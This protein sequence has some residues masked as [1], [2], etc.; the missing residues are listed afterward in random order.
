META[1]TQPAVVTSVGELIGERPRFGQHTSPNGRP[2]LEGASY[3][4][5][6]GLLALQI[7]SAG[8]V[9]VGRE[10][11]SSRLVSGLP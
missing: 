3:L 10:L 2:P 7:Q 9:E 1:A 4:A 6:Q 8:Q 11:L 5:P